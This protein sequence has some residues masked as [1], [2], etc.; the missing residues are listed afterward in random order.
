MRRLLFIVAMSC[1]TLAVGAQSATDELQSDRRRSASNLMV[2]PEPLQ[3]LT[4]SPKGKRPFYISH[5]GRHGSRYQ[6][7]IGDFDYVIN[8]LLQASRRNALSPLGSDVLRRLEQMRA[9]S[10]EHIGELSSLGVTQQEGIATRMYARFPDIFSRN[11]FVDA[12]STLS[13]RCILSMNIFLLQLARHNPSLQIVQDASMAD[14]YYMMPTDMTLAGR[15]ASVET[16]EEYRDW[17]DRHAKWQRVVN[18]LFCDT[19]FVTHRVNGPRLNY[20]LF[21]LAS[22][23]QNT[24]PE[25][26]LTL[27]DLFT[28]EEIYAN[29]SRE[30]AYWYLTS[31]FASSSGG[32]QPFAA[33]ALLRRIIEQADSSMHQPRPSAHLRFGHDTVLLPLVCLM[34]VNGFD[35]STSDLSQLETHGWLNYRV[36][37]MAA[38]L[39]LV[40][41]RKDVNDA[42]IVFKVLLNENEA[43]LPIPTDITPYYHWRDFR[44]YC[45][46]RIN[47]Y[48]ARQT[49]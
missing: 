39:Q 35:F 28:D 25:D 42:D 23:L 37:P 41:Y 44:D 12:R 30:N 43:T 49:R 15:G 4:P 27:Y 16:K 38:N 33:R 11:A 32:E 45:L 40:F 8:T 17:C 6:T 19:A 10:L 1:L 14:L 47:D 48:E 21:R 20:Y 24:E 5:Y 36:F 46:Q 7:R 31:G 3:R 22:G 13:V 26:G 29:W 18:Q 2:Y 9:A 34:G